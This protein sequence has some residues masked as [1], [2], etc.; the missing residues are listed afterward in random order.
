MAFI[1]MVNIL[2]NTNL[3]QCENTTDTQQNLLLETVLPVTSIKRM[4]DRTVEFRVHIVVG[5]EQVQLDTTYI[6]TPYIGMNLIIHIR[7]IYD[8]RVT[9]GVELTFDRQREIGRAHV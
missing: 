8:N 6:D 2:G 5:I 7:Y 4:G 1:A 9:I 3:L